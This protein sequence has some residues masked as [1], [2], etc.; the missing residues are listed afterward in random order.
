M[1]PD[2]SDADQFAGSINGIYHLHSGHISALPLENP[3]P[4]GRCAQVF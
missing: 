1:I 3:G 4:E 2:G